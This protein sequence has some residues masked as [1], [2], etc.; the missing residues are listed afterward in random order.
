VGVVWQEQRNRAKVLQTTSTVIYWDC[1]SGMNDFLVKN[2]A[3]VRKC[4]VLCILC[5]I[6]G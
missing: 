2:S 6:I 5:K 4:T 3:F 1:L